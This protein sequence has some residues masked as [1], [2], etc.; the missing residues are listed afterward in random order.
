MSLSDPLHSQWYT[1][2]VGSALN[3]HGAL[4]YSALTLFT[5]WSVGRVSIRF[6]LSGYIRVFAIDAY[7]SGR[8]QSYGTFE[9]VH[10]CTCKLRV[11][12][13]Y[14]WSTYAVWNPWTDRS[15]CDCEV[16]LV[17][18]ANETG[19]KRQRETIHERTFVPYSC[20]Y[21]MVRQPLRPLTFPAFNI[22]KQRFAVVSVSMYTVSII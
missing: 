3:R 2:T 15:V 20:R 22:L 17:Q 6:S 7:V 10:L 8:V 14:V 18:L 16:R 1:I 5:S 13:G 9:R 4:A 19:S 12:R 21:R 11:S